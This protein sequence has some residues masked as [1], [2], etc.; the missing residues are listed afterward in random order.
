MDV[1]LA[2]AVP[3]AAC[4]ETATLV[5]VL[6]VLN[7]MLFAD[8]LYATVCETLAAV[9][10]AGAL[11]TVSVYVLVVVPFCAVTTV[12]MTLLPTFKLIAPLA[13]PEAT[14]VPFTVIVAFAWVRVGVTVTDDTEFATDAV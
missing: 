6:V 4:V 7:V 12:V 9:G 13:V 14:A 11:V 8:E 1:A 5:G 2:V 3:F 10:A